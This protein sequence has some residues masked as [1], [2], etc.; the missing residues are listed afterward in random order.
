MVLKKGVCVSRLEACSEVAPPTKTLMTVAK[1]AAEVRFRIRGKTSPMFNSAKRAAGGKVKASKVEAARV[2]KEVHLLLERRWLGLGEKAQRSSLGRRSMAGPMI[3]GWGIRVLSAYKDKVK[4]EKALDAAK[5]GQTDVERDGGLRERSQLFVQAYEVR[6]QDGSSKS[7][8]GR[9]TKLNGAVTRC[10]YTVSSSVGESFSEDDLSPGLV[11]FDGNYFY[12][13][14]EAEEEARVSEEQ[15]G[16]PWGYPH[17]ARSRCARPGE[18]LQVFH[19]PVAECGA[20]AY[21]TGQGL[22]DVKVI[23]LM[24]LDGRELRTA[25]TYSEGLAQ[26]RLQQVDRKATVRVLLTVR[27]HPI[28]DYRLPRP[29][30]QT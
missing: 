9:L 19:S 12:M 18:V 17:N 29:Q 30:R 26:V 2:A 15:R 20:N 28:L 6:G 5:K 23:G 22:N 8:L 14:Q 10:V 24:S 7:E 13:N 27:E 3:E 25:V 1:T 16:T 21:A 11:E 4:A